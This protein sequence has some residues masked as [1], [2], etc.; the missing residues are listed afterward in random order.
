VFLLAAPVHAAPTARVDR[1]GDALP[2]GAVA[3]LGTLAQRLPGFTVMAVRGDGLL[4]T[5]DD[6][7]MVRFYDP[8]AGRVVRQYRLG[9]EGTR[10]EPVAI[11]PDGRTLATRESEAVGLWDLDIGQRRT[12]LAGLTSRF[13]V[14]GVFS[15]DGR[16]LV[17]TR[18]DRGGLDRVE[19]W[20][21]AT[22][23]LR[24]GTPADGIRFAVA[25]SPNGR[26]VAIP[27][28]G[29]R[30]WDMLADR[31][32]WKGGP[33]FSAAALVFSPDGR[34]VLTE[35]PF[36]H[37]GL[38]D[39]ATGKPVAGAKFPDRSARQ[40]VFAPDGTA[41]FLTDFEGVFL[42]DFTT[43]R[44]RYRL[45]G[46][47]WGSEALAFSSDGKAVV[48]AHR[49][50]GRVRWYD[51]A[52]GRP[53]GPDT[54]A[55]GHAHPIYRVALSPDGRTA[56]T[57]AGAPRQETSLRLWETATGRPVRSLRFEDWMSDLAF[58]PDGRYLVGGYAVSMTAPPLFAVWEVSTGRQVAH[59][60]GIEAGDEDLWWLSGIR[61]SANGRQL[62]ALGL[63]YDD[64]RLTVTITTWE[65]PTGRA[66]GRNRFTAPVRDRLSPFGALSPDG[67]L[68]AVPGGR[69]FDARTGRLRFT[70]AAEGLVSDSIVFS[71]DG[72]LIAVVI[73]ANRVGDDAR[74]AKLGVHVWEAATGQ[75]VA[76]IPAITE[77]FAFAPDNRM[78]VTADLDGAALRLWDL[79]S[80]RPAGQRPMGETAAAP[81]AR[82]L[83]FA[84]DGRSLA[85]GHADGTLLVWDLA[86]LAQRPPVPPPAEADLEGLWSDL[87]GDAPAAYTAITRLTA[88]PGPAVAFLRTRLKP[89]KVPTE[90]VRRWLTDLDSPTFA[91]RESA[92]RALADL[93]D[94]AEPALREALASK[95]TLEQRRRLERLL[96]G[97][98]TVP[99]P[100]VVRVLRAVQ[101]LERAGTPEAR[102][103]LT[104]LAGGAAAARE[105]QAASAALGRL[106]ATK[107]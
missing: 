15:A 55:L 1:H 63:N 27:D 29:L 92:A 91:R 101:V 83:A 73:E 30:C 12:R 86:A 99:S 28:D 40:G 70:L 103:V 52:T 48:A 51:I 33:F 35:D 34:S 59:W 43:G 107:G 96:D 8:A 104:A 41:V 42:W 80:G 71:P 61:I 102:A 16:S 74:G 31:E 69:V 6:R 75:T 85:T 45:A 9:T 5:C 13:E 24:A 49:G 64:D 3:R 56:A 19:V 58:T 53:F 66:V 22:G 65:L 17:T 93:G 50:G 32:L 36:G 4:V 68:V 7:A 94:R 81:L 98:A 47:S 11:A 77:Q 76:H 100:D 84:P 14:R 72:A 25:V 18:T 23:G 62:T 37:P 54:D 60:E 106:G 26:L 10:P 46:T 88:A 44:E 105:T 21:T 67:A 89:V 2:E 82:G 39:A 78:M 57:V 20:D 97:T 90:D 87:A 38:Y 95:P 79:P